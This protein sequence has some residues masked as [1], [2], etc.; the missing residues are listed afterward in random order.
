MISLSEALKIMHS[1]ALF[2]LKC[3]TH[4]RKR[5]DRSGRV[6]F[7]ERGKL[8]WGDGVRKKPIIVAERNLTA[9]ERKLSGADDKKRNP[10]H[11]NHFTRNVRQYVGDLPTADIRKIHVR[12]II[13][14]NGQPT[15][16]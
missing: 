8:V 2:S 10:H 5:A 13:E 1:G 11:K 9:L 3:V 14:F 12:L 15:T 16:P 4:D 7:I 6:L